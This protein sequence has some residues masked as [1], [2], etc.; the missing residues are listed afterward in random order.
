LWRWFSAEDAAGPIR[1]HDDRGDARPLVHVRL[2]EPIRVASAGIRPRL[3]AARAALLRHGRVRRLVAATLI[4][5]LHV[6]AAYWFFKM[7][8]PVLGSGGRLLLLG[9][10]AVVGLATPI[11]F[12]R[13][14]A[15]VTAG[16]IR[17]TM[18][19]HGFCPSC[20][21][22]L[23]ESSGVVEGMTTCGECGARWRVSPAA[24]QESP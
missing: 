13:G 2:R 15:G 21:A 11:V 4:F 16:H 17:T 5:A 14:V 7:P 10:I 3:L 6:N 22:D 8:G 1:I 9:F 12:L 18:I 20:A 23:G 19:R 24:A